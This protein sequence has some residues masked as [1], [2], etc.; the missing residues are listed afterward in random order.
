MNIIPQEGQELAV[1][2]CF[3]CGFILGLCGGL[4][5]G[6]VCLDSLKRRIEWLESS[7]MHRETPP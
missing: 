1:F 3:I 4:R 6:F 2:A 7:L 5:I